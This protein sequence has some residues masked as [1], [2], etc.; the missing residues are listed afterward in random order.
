MFVSESD[1]TWAILLTCMTILLC[2]RLWCSKAC[3]EC[4]CQRNYE[5]NLKELRLTVA[6]F[7]LQFPA[8]IKAILLH[9]Y[10]FHLLLIDC[11]EAINH[12]SAQK[13][14]SSETCENYVWFCLFSSV[15]FR[16]MFFYFAFFFNIQS[17][18]LP[19]YNLRF[20]GYTSLSMCLKNKLMRVLKTF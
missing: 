20:S 7:S 3:W 13:I 15:C 18:P 17:P 1:Q 16:R 14:L 2:L 10:D 9:N 5:T 19:K 4:W 8:N 11:C 12:N 6:A